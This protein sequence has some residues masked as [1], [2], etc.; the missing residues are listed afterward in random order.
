VALE[1]VGHFSYYGVSMDS[2]V[3]RLESDLPSMNKIARKADEKMK[4]GGSV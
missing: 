3:R 4:E 2:D 1:G